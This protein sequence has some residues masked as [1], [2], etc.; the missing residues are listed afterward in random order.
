MAKFANWH[1]QAWET[2]VDTP[3]VQRGT[4]TTPGRRSWYS[5]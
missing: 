1:E 4:G 5:V 3:A 2:E